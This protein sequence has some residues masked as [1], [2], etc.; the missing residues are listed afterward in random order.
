MMSASAKKIEIR[1]PIGY[2]CVKFSNPKKNSNYFLVVVGSKR[3]LECFLE[4]V[5]NWADM[6]PQL[7]ADVY[8]CFPPFP[9]IH[10]Q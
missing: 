6:R 5:I 10:P 9:S 8:F 7:T 1:F 3:A 4:W 2:V